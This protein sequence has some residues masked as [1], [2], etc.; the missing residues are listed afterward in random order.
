MK[1][2][3]N[4]LK[5]KRMNKSSISKI[6]IQPDSTNTP[7]ISSNIKIKPSKCKGCSRKKEDK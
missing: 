6:D 3:M 4:V 7:S 5:K 2:Q 1:Q